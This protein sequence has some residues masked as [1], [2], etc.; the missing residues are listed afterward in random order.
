M[1]KAGYNFASPSNLGNKVSNTVNKERDIT[2]TQKKLKEHA[3]G[4]DNNKAGL[5]F[6][7]NK[8]VKI[9]RKAKNASAQH[10]SISVEQNQEEHKPTP[11]MQSLIG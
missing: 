4:V 3:Y 6:T 9:S 1:S 8:L 2:E 10:I 11:R 5:G 7:P